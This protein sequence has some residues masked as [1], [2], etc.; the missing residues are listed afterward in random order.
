MTEEFLL[1]SEKTSRASRTSENTC[2]TSLVDKGKM[3]GRSCYYAPALPSHPPS[4]APYLGPD[5][6]AAK[7]LT[8]FT[9][10]VG[11]SA[12]FGGL[13]LLGP[14]GVTDR[15]RLRRVVRDDGALRRL[16][17]PGLIAVSA[18]ARWYALIHR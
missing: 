7:L 17:V 1:A 18:P 5:F 12:V 10:V 11:V 4:R 6:P 3:K 16:V 15:Q 8:L 2:S 13:G 9:N 14:L